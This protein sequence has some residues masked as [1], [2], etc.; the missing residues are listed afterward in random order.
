MGQPVNPVL[1]YNMLSPIPYLHRALDIPYYHHERWDGTGYP[2]GLKGEGIPFAARLFAIIDVW[3]A[4]T[5][6][7][8]SHKTLNV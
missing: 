6:I 7:S 2:C 3:D 4:K 1:A 8:A 5:P